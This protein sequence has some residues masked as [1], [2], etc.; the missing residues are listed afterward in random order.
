MVGAGIEARGLSSDLPNGRTRVY[1]YGF[2]QYTREEAV[3][4]SGHTLLEIS[5]YLTQAQRSPQ[6][7]AV[8]FPGG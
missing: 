6:K 8:Y 4:F 1:F 3:N 5:D 7:V 2:R